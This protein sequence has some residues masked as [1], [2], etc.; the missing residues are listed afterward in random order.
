MTHIGI[1]NFFG[2]IPKDYYYDKSGGYSIVVQIVMDYNKQ[3]FD[4]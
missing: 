4:L 3:F 1:A 2:P